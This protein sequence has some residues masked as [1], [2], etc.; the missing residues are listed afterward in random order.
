MERSNEEEVGVFTQEIEGVS[1]A[2]AADG[3][4]TSLLRSSHNDMYREIE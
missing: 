3:R 2:A 4:M 1:M